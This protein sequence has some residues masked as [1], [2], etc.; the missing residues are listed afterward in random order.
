MFSYREELH[1]DPRSLRKRNKRVL[2]VWDSVSRKAHSSFLPSHSQSK[3]G[4]GHGDNPEEG[5][6]ETAFTVKFLK[7]LQDDR[8]LP[9]PPPEFAPGKNNAYSP[10]MIHLAQEQVPISRAS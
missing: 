4:G 5:T 7:V 6:K 10:Q 1:L 8:M 9:L 3:G 2:W